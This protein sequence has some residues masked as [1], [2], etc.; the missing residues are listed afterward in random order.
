M[1][2][3]KELKKNKKRNEKLEKKRWLDRR[4]IKIKNKWYTKK[5]EVLL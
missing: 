4:S 2:K 5:K 3:N 1:G